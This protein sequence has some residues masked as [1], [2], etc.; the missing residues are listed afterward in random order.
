T[1]V[2]NTEYQD[3]VRIWQTVLDRRPHVRAHA[4]IATELRDQ[5]RIEESISHLRIAAPADPDAQHAL[6][7][8]LL[9]RGDVAGGVP[10]LEEFVGKYPDDPHLV[11]AREELA[12]GLYKQG[13]LPAAI[14]QYNAVVAASPDYAGGRLNLANL[15][16]SAR[17]F[18]E[19]AAQYREALRL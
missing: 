16:L 14:T 10:Q 18:S 3:G 8:A 6:G 17:R 19:A 4:N 11:G 7:S 9:E 1:I 2:R 12:A 15:L 13:K 5:G